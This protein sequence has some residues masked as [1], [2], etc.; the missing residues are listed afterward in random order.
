MSCSNEAAQALAA[1]RGRVPTTAFHR[2]TMTDDSWPKMWAKHL[3]WKAWT[4]DRN[5]GGTG[6]RAV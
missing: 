3:H 5:G 1:R 4:L 6:V 2:P